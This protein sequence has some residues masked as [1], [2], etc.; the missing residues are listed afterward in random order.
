[1]LWRYLYWKWLVA[2]QSNDELLN[3]FWDQQRFLKEQR[4][5]KESL[6]IEIKREEIK[7]EEPEEIKELSNQTRSE[8]WQLAKY[9]NVQEERPDIQWKY[10]T[11]REL[12][13][14]ITSYLRKLSYQQQIKNFIDQDYETEYEEYKRKFGNDDESDYNEDEELKS[15]PTTQEELNRIENDIQRI[16]DQI[17]NLDEDDEKHPSYQ[18]TIRDMTIKKWRKLLRVLPTRLQGYITLLYIGNEEAK[19][20][21]D[22]YFTFSP[23]TKRELRKMQITNYDLN[24]PNSGEQFI[25]NLRKVGTVTIYFNP[26]ESYLSQEEKDRRRGRGGF[27][28]FLNKTI[29]DLERYQI[30]SKVDKKNY[31]T[32]CFIYALEKSEMFKKS[33]IEDIKTMVIDSHIR[34][35]DFDQITK[36][37]KCNIKL[38]KENDQA[39]WYPTTGK[40]YSEY[41]EIGLIDDH[42]FIVEPTKYNRFAIDNYNEVKH[43]NKWNT[44][45]KI[46]P[47]RHR[48][49]NPLNSFKLIK[50]MKKNNLFEPIDMSTEEI[51][52]TQYYKHVNQEITELDYDEGA[53][54]PIEPKKPV[55]HKGPI[56]YAD[57]E[58]TTDGDK[59]IPYMC[60]VVGENEGKSIEKTFIGEYCGKKLLDYLPNDSLI[61]FHNFGYDFSFLV[62]YLGVNK[63]IK[64]GTQ[65]KLVKAIYKKKHFVLK[66]SLA[67]IAEPL[68]KFT[69]M[70]KLD[71]K[72][73]IMPYGLYTKESV[74]KDDV[75]Y[76]DCKLHIAPQDWPEFEILARPYVFDNKFDLIDYAEFYCLQDCRVLMQ[77]MKKFNEWM[78][79]AFK[80]SV[81]NF[82]SLPSL[83]FQYLYEEKCFEGIY[84]LSGV[85]RL[86]IQ[87]CVKGGRCMTRD[88]KKWLV[89]KPINDFDAVSL[90]PSAMA[91]MGFLKGKPI[92]LQ[93]DQLNMEFLNRQSGY[94]VEIKNLF[95]PKSRHFPLQSELSDK[96]IRN[97]TNEFFKNVCVD[98]VSL[99]DLIEFQD[100]QF[101]I[102][103]GYYFNEG[104]NYN[105]K[106]T[107]TKCFNQRLIKKQEK[108]PIEQVYKLLMNASY[109]KMIQKPIT[110]KIHFSNTKKQHHTFLLKQHDFISEFTEVAKD[111]YVYKVRKSILRHFNAAHCG[112]EI[113]SMSKRIMNE[114]MCLAED[115]DCSIYYQDTDSMHISDEDI[116]KLIVAFRE[117][118]NRELKG[119]NMGQFHSDFSVKDKRNPEKAL[120]ELYANQCIFLGKKAYIDKLTCRDTN[121]TQHMKTNYHFRMKGITQEAIQSAGDPFEI[122]QR[123]YNGEKI[124]F[125]I[126]KTK[127]LFKR[128]KD[129][130]YQTNLEFKRSVKFC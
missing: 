42:F 7:R 99:E 45:T 77:G 75:P 119:N 4:E 53:V 26:R 47:V 87:Q 82:I 63:F 23:Q 57:F 48:I 34:L 105:I 9:Y 8:L 35:N 113:L 84:E 83:A 41:I 94:F 21:S 31:N 72:K 86:F 127:V 121:L 29:I 97:Y 70:F 91:R 18:I 73:E 71:S 40:N 50:L 90:Y 104:R 28:A 117:K 60:C 44:L 129:F 49:K 120:D 24:S 110:Q 51:M 67:M 123:L 65:I 55:E 111:K 3:N 22:M 56:F 66:D 96:G 115:I 15:D 64:T 100:A 17:N 122:Y 108:N 37:L 2:N 106:D 76:E 13:D 46:D 125:D 79:T 1:M 16:I 19:S 11:V 62:K 14:Y 52:S 98:K 68:K 109:G 38:Y 93:Q 39:R 102:V 116:E 30:Y 12:T 74:N 43:M 89:E 85:P 80:L 103:R 107:I 69:K 130:S 92:V 36:I 124:T 10:T 6:P 25:T 61:Y 118:Y 32:N 20:N 78:V 101:D 5:Q 126:A 81:Y 58:T 59:H 88:N 33:K 27:F 128:N 112:T 95:V 54:R 114:V